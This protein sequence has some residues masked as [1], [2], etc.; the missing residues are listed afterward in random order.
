M[1]INVNTSMPP[2]NSETMAGLLR[3]LVDDLSILFRKEMALAKAEVSQAVDEAK[4][5]IAGIAVGGAVLYAGF[6]T[7]LAAF[8]MLLAR[9]M[10]AWGAALLVGAVTVIAGY[11]MVQAARKKFSPTNLKP[12]LTKESLRRDKEVLQR[13]TA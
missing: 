3:R 2:P 1:A 11:A 9:V 8:V 13:R 5:G 4:A 7:V 10:P 12:E 6:L